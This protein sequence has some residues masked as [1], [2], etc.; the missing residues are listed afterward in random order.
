LLNVSRG[1]LTRRFSSSERIPLGTL[2]AFGQW[3]MS[4]CSPDWP[5]RRWRPWP[6]GAGVPADAGGWG[7]RWGGRAAVACLRAAPPQV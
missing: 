7:L 2:E 4:P 3:G 5:R 6:A 1:P